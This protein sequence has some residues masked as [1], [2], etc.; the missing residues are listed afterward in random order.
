MKDLKKSMTCRQTDRLTDSEEEVSD[1]QKISASY[2]KIIKLYFIGNNSSIA[3]NKYWKFDVKNI[4]NLTG[5]ILNI[6]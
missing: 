5:K 1:S 6:P 3:I 4:E 2:N